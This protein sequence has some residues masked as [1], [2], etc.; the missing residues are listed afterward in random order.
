MSTKITPIF[1]DRLCRPT[2]AKLCPVS[3][4]PKNKPTNPSINQQVK[5]NFYQSMTI[6]DLW[7]SISR[8]ITIKIREKE[9]KAKIFSAKI[10]AKLIAT[11]TDP[12]TFQSLEQSCLKRQRR[13]NQKN[14]SKAYWV[15]KKATEKEVIWDW[16]IS[17][18]AKVAV[19]MENCEQSPKVKATS[20]WAAH[21]HKIT[22][23]QRYLQN[24]TAHK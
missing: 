16:Q 8:K 4:L 14:S 19:I 18:K 21:K 1:R 22:P 23:L 3:K 24:T 17:R 11:V 13:V 9:S 2:K 6:M 5:N 10:A 15:D 7:S 12:V 20:K